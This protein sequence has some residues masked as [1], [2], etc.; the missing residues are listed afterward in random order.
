MAI[1][2]NA[3]SAALWYNFPIFSNTKIDS[4]M[5]AENDVNEEMWRSI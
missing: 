2:S 3:V 4:Y 5:T 1:I